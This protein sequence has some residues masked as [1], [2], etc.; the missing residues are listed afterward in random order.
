MF[1]MQDSIAIESGG[2]VALVYDAK[3]L[4][5]GMEQQR[6]MCGVHLNLEEAEALRDHIDKYID[7]METKSVARETKGAKGETK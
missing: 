3:W 2:E 1:K 5:I 6:M 7:W 4:F